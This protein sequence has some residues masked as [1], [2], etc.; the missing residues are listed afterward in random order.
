MVK[1]YFENL[2]DT[3]ESMLSDDY[4]DR[5]VAEYFQL[6]IRYNKLCKFC[7][8]YRDGKLDFTPDCTLELLL[9]QKLI[10]SR[11]MSILE[12]RFVAEEISIDCCSEDN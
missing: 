6:K 3:V 10:M 8:R 12:R 9:D 1:Y 11:Y 4:I 7:E 5:L 2:K